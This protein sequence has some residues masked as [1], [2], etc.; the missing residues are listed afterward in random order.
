MHGQHNLLE[1]PPDAYVERLADRLAWLESRTDRLM[2][3]RRRRHAAPI[4]VPVSR[5]KTA[6]RSWEPGRSSGS[7]IGDADAV[8][9]GRDGR[10]RRL[11]AGK[12]G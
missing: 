4:D 7:S 9:A 3:E 2:E 11:V 5:S 8:L 6:T 10:D 12:A 1:P